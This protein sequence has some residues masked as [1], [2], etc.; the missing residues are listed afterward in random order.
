MQTYRTNALFA[1]ILLL[2]GS[3][4]LVQA[5]LVCTKG[6]SGTVFYDSS[7][8]TYAYVNDVIDPQH[9]VAYGSFV[10]SL[11]TTGW[12]VLT[13]STSKS[14]SNVVQVQYFWD[15]SPSDHGSS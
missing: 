2:V 1:V 15:I 8:G 12:G 7:T 10:D 3:S 5:G 4:L 6:C 13:I 9:G 14:F 11:N